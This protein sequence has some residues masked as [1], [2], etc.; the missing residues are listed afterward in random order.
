MQRV[1]DERREFQRLHLPSPLGG[2]AGG[3]DAR[4]EEIGILGAGI[5]HASGL[6]AGPI[7]LRFAYGAETIALRC[8]VVRTVATRDG[9]QS[10]LRFL[11]AM[12]NSGDALR[13]MLA[14][15]VTYELERRRS[16]PLATD[17]IPFDGD[18]TIRGARAAFVCYRLEG[19]FWK[20]RSVFLPEQPASGFTV[21]RSADGGEMQRLCRVYQ[22]SDDEGRRLIRLFAE[23]S[24][25]AALEIPPRG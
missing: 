11:T 24:V 9:F 13:R 5:R 21:P 22:A 1:P 12:G 20:R 16:A 17:S 3:V 10:G 19:A 23:L 7:D 4:I 8:D 2:T 18:Q 14:D 25:G 15:V 6:P